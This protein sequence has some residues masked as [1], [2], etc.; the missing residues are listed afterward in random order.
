[1]SK[2]NQTFKIKPDG[3]LIQIILEAFGLDNLED[4]RF[5]TKEHMK[6]IQ[7]VDK[8]NKLQINNKFLRD[9][10]LPCKGKRY[11]KDLD[12]K[13]CITILRQCIRIHN[14]KCIGMEKSV[15]GKKTMTY[16]LIYNNNDSLKSPHDEKEQPYILSFE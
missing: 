16:R 5:F 15:S 7:T 9:Y 13:K 4:T 1:M 12:E 10:Y 3:Q 6:D 2:K 14:Y 8:L 11:L